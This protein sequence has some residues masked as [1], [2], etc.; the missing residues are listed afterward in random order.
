MISRAAKLVVYAACIGLFGLV[1][2]AQLW[3]WR[4]GANYRLNTTPSMPVGLW[5]V[6]RRTP[7]MDQL[8][9]GEAVSVCLPLLVAIPAR[10]RGYVSGGECPGRTT[11]MLKTIA[12]IPGDIVTVSSSGMAVNGHVLP[13]SRPLTRDEKGRPLFAVPVGS[14]IVP[15]TVVWLYASHDPRSF[16]SRYYGAIPAR[17]VIGHAW[18]LLVL[19]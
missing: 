9:R 16:D 3:V 5:A 18:P 19:K 17:N 8:R 1:T 4:S 12:A 14:Y 10:R 6:S 15:A 11:P 2:G 7:A 13:H